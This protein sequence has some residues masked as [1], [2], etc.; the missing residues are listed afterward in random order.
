M[1]AL[2]DQSTRALQLGPNGHYVF[3][4]YDLF[5]KK[6]DGGFM[7][8]TPSEV[9]ACYRVARQGL[10]V[11]LTHTYC[12]YSLL[13]DCAGKSRTSARSSAPR[14]NSCWPSRWARPATNTSTTYRYD[15]LLP[16]RIHP[17]TCCWRLFQ[18][19]PVQ[20]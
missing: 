12:V 11:L 5:P 18:T 8:N 15:V 6:A 7:F 9:R 16:A 20:M 10:A 3:S 14:R 19:F 2:A 1:H 13:R 17:S 4:G